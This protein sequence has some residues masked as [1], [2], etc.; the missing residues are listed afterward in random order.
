MSVGNPLAYFLMHTTEDHCT[1]TLALL[2]TLLSQGASFDPCHYDYV[3]CGRETSACTC[4]T[5]AVGPEAAAHVESG[6]GACAH[7]LLDH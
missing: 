6:K 7:M 1:G 5:L 3:S 2:V 4:A